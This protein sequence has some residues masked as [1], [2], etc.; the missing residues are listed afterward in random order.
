VN[1]IIEKTG[2]GVIGFIS[3]ITL[4]EINAFLSAL[5]AILTIIYLIVSIRKKLGK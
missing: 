1:E 4:A 3:S 5:V 2:V